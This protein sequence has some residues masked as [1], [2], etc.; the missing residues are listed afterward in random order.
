[1]SRLRGGNTIDKLN[2]LLILKESEHC[3]SVLTRLMNITFYPVEN[4][5]AFRVNVISCIHEIMESI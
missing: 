3:K 1:V 5:M 4:N 2:Q